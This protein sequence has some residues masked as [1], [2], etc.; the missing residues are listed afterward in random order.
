MDDSGRASRGEFFDHA[1]AGL[2]RRHGHHG[3]RRRR[4][5]HARPREGVRRRRRQAASGRF[6][7]IPGPGE[8][9]SRDLAAGQRL[10]EVRRRRGVADAGHRSR[11][12]ARLFLDGQRGPRLQRRRARRRQSLHGV[13]RRVE[14]K[15]G[16]YRWHFQQVHHDIWDYDSS[17]PVVLMDLERRGPRAQS[18]RRGRQDGLG[19]HSRS[20]DRRADRRHRRAARRARAAAS[21]RRDAAVPAR[22]RRRAAGASRSRPRVTSSS[23]KGASSRRSPARI[24][25]S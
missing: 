16:K 5:R 22:R 6:T 17:N 10:V 7:S 8:P 18:D 13:D 15:T 21:D 12:R 20:R 23:T 2:F 24:R 25:R 9:G 4:S 19:V 14:L 3:L 11:A 1:G